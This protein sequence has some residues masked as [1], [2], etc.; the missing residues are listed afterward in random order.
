M[1]DRTREE[2]C[3]RDDFIWKK[4]DTNAHVRECLR[5]MKVCFFPYRSLMKMPDGPGRFELKYVPLGYFGGFRRHSRLLSNVSP[6]PTIPR[7]TYIIDFGLYIVFKEVLNHVMSQL[8]IVFIK[9]CRSLQVSG[10]VRPNI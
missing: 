6:S 1:P 9:L 4:M 8:A 5:H 10:M 7:L 3:S 2:C